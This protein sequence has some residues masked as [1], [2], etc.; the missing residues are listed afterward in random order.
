MR[1]AFAI[2]FIFTCTIAPHMPLPIFTG[3]GGS[4]MKQ[5][6]YKNLTYLFQINFTSDTAIRFYF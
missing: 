4:A 2:F 3:K 5:F 1:T 6:W